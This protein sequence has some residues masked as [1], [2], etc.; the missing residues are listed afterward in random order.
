[1]LAIA[2][3]RAGVSKVYAIEVGTMAD[4]AEAFIAETEVASKI[5]LIWGWSTQINLQEKTDV[6][7][8]EI[9]G[10]DPF[11][12]NILQ[13]FNDARR[14]LLKPGA[15]LIPSG[16]TLFGMPALIAPSVIKN[17]V[18]LPRIWKTGKN[19]TELTLRH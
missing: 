13:K 10:N 9:I 3:A 4:V 17:R 15:R 12:E 1:M 14:R 8:G 19:G 5:V 16:I 18:L 6:T 11:G 7:V 2:A